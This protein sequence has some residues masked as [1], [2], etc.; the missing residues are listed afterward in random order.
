[1]ENAI[2]QDI[3]AEAMK[4]GWWTG[5]VAA[6][7][8]HFPD[9]PIDKIEAAAMRGGVHPPPPIIPGCTPSGYQGSLS[10]IDLPKV[11]GAIH[12]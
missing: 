4:L 8:K 10:P 11:L 12:G 3:Y 7:A 6:L 1:M 5:T 2:Y 9:V